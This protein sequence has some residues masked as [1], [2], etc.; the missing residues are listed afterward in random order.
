[1]DALEQT[2]RS[3][4]AVA[5]DTG[6]S[7]EQ[8]KKLSQNKSRST[9]VDDAVKIANYFGMTLDE[10]IGDDTSARRSAI[11]DLYSRL[12]P[13]EQEFLLAA[14]KGLHAQAQQGS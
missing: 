1:M 2:N 4:R 7:Y 12:E 5:L 6:V 14:A 8:L 10:F 13:Q 9:N 11:L 3:L